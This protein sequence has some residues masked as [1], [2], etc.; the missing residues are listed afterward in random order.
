MQTQNIYQTQ[1]SK[2]SVPSILPL[3]KEHIDLGH[4]GIVNHSI[5]FIN[6]KLKKNNKGMDRNNKIK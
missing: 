2:E 5:Q 1:I 4:A 3:L 6:T